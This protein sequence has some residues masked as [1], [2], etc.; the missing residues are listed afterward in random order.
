MTSFLLLV[1]AR[2]L[3]SP[4]PP[5]YFFTP[6]L[7]A[8]LLIVDFAALSEADALDLSPVVALVRG[9]ATRCV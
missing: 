3:P 2:V 6:A 5:L 7:R 9:L 4:R 8:R 1:V